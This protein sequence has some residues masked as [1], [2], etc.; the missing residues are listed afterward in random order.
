MPQIRFVSGPPQ[1]PGFF[2]QLLGAIV[3]IAVLATSVILGAFLLAG[4]I[5]FVLIVA[6]VFYLR[7]W[8]L[9]RQMDVHDDEEDIIVTEYR[10]IDSQDQDSPER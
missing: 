2:M 1:R 9:R 4:L 8:W 10:V 7:I 5:G 3:G 6:I